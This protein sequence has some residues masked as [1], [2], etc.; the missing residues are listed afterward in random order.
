MK[1]LW[2]KLYAKLNRI[3]NS[4]IVNHFFRNYFSTHDEKFIPSKSYKIYY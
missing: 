2:E 3:D 4:S 1:F